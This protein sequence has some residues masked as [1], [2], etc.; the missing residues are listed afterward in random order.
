MLRAGTV[1][2]NGSEFETATLEGGSVGVG[3]LE[4]L[5][6]IGDVFEVPV[7]GPTS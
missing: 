1:I 5:M 3:P 2:R 4:E 6:E 7:E